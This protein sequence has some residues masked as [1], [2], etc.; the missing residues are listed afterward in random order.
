[1]FKSF[2]KSLKKVNQSYVDKNEKMIPQYLRI[3]DIIVRYA[4]KA[5]NPFICIFSLQKQN[6]CSI[7]QTREVIFMVESIQEYN[8]LKSNSQFKVCFFDKKRHDIE[9]ILDIEDIEKYIERINKSK[10]VVFN[11]KDEDKNVLMN[12]LSNLTILRKHYS[13]IVE[14]GDSKVFFFPQ[15]NY[16][17]IYLLRALFQQ[18]Y[19][20]ETISI[21]LGANASVE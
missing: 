9:C 17:D 16:S 6:I 19:V 21:N 3:C 13:P 20:N 2:V 5:M 8:V 1:M 7:M 15:L 10:L 14:V 18:K 11:V 12:V 4:L